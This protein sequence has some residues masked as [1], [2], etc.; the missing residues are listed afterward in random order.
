MRITVKVKPNAQKNE[1][2]RWF[3]ET[4]CKIAVTAPPTDGQANKELIS[5]LADTLNVP[6]QSVNIIHGHGGRK[7]LLELPDETQS[8]LRTLRRHLSQ[9]T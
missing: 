8:K 4:T 5:Y 9:G 2:K 3:D 1:I 6:R 7:K